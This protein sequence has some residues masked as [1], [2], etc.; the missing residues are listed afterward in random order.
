MTIRGPTVEAVFCSGANSSAI[1]LSPGFNP[2]KHLLTLCVP[3]EL[4]IK[5]DTVKSGCSIVCIH[6]N[7]TVISQDSPLYILRG[8]GL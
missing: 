8:H 3:M 7:D 4:P 1:F 2:G 5:N 6:K